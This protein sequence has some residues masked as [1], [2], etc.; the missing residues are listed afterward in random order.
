M[1][2]ETLSKTKH[3][4]DCVRMNK[5]LLY[6]T[7]ESTPLSK[8]DEEC[9]LF[10]ISPEKF[11]RYYLDFRLESVQ[12]EQRSSI[13]SF[14]VRKKAHLHEPPPLASPSPL[15]LGKEAVGLG[16]SRQ[17]PV[18]LSHFIEVMPPINV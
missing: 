2:T 12:Q 1:I 9:Q 17:F 15:P 14:K 8:Y 16:P 13:C 7:M 11:D 10:M 6:G 18:L 3:T 5:G 4:Q